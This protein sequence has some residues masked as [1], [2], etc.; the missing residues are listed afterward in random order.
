MNE[1]R[2]EQCKE[3]IA[4]LQ[5]KLARLEAARSKPRH[6][7][8]VQTHNQFATNEPRIILIPKGGTPASYDAA[9]GMQLGNYDSGEVAHAY[10]SG[11]YTVVGNAF[12]M[13]EGE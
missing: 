3:Y 6:G 10:A 8:I 9:G 2:I 5:A 1:Q 7:D 11:M 12:D 13:A 4:T